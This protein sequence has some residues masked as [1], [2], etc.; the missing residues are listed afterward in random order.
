MAHHEHAQRS[1]VFAV[2]ILVR[3]ILIQCA[4]D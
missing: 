3:L 1:A 4:P 2:V